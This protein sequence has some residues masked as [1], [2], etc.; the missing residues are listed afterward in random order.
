[1]PGRRYSL[2]TEA[3]NRLRVEPRLIRGVFKVLVVGAP[4][5][6]HIEA[7]LVRLQGGAGG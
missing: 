6:L 3:L 2:A 7:V 1:M 4:H 5:R